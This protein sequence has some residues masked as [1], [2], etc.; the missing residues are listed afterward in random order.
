[1]KIQVEVNGT[2]REFQADARE[3]VRDLL[4]REGLLSVRNG[5]DGQ[6]T[7]G[8]CSILLDGKVV[9]SCLLLAPQV[10]GRKIRTAEHLSRDRE[11]SAVQTAFIDAGV[12]Q[13]GYCTPALLLAT[14]ELLARH[15]RPSREQVQDAFSGIFCRCTGYQQLFAAV[16]LAARRRVEPAHAA[17]TAPEFRED[18]RVVGKVRRKVDAPRLVRAEKSYVED[19][20]EPGACH[21]RMLGSP[22]A[23]AYIKRLDTRAAEAMP[24]V[25][26]VLTHRNTPEVYYNQAGQGFPEPSPYDRRLFGQKVLHVGDRVAAVVAETPEIAAEALRKIRVEYEVLKPVL[27][28]E[29]AAAPDAPRLH[30][31]VLEYVTGAPADLD[32]SGADPRD[33]KVLYQFPIHADPRR[34][35]A[36]SVSGGIGDVEAGLRQAEVVLEREYET[37]QVQCT[38]LEPHVVYT[39]M[40]GERLVIH[41]STQVPW[42]VRRIV[43]RVLGVSENQV[44]VI[45]ERI[46]GGFGA[47]QDVVL[48]EVAAYA[49]WVTRRP[50]LYR[51]TREEE[52]IASRTRHPMKIRVTLGARKDGK[53]TAIRMNVR[54]NTGP[55]GAHCLTV[56]MNAC[57]KSL[58]LLLCENVRFDVTTYYSNIPP[59]GAYQG[60]GAPQGS[61]ALQLACAEMAEQLGVDPLAFLETNRVRDGS[62]LEILRCL[63]EGREGRPQAVS[64]CGLGPALQQGAEMLRWGAPEASADP[65]VRIGKGVAI[66]QQASGLPGI[67]S[68]NAT[69][70]LLGDGTLMLLSGGTDLGTGLDTLMVKVVAECLCAPMGDVSLIVADTDVTPYDDGAYASSGTFFSGSAALNAA[71]DMKQKILEVAAGLLGEPVADLELAYPS[72]VQGK[73]GSAS[74][75]QVARATQSGTGAGQ[76][77][78]TASFTTDKAAFPY[79]AHFCQAAVNT[80]TGA[81][82]LQKYYALQ[83]CGTPIN[84]ELALGQIYGGALKTI[85]HSLYEEMLLDSKGRCLNANL[86]DYKV[87]M[88]RDLPADFR[89]V[90]VETTDPFGPYGGKSVSE[91]SCNGAAPAIAA[92]IHDATGVWLRS[93]PFTPEKIL[94]ALG[95][96]PG[97]ARP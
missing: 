1:M 40:D 91:I 16:E 33:G 59:C 56:P 80:R 32:N 96:L 93:W 31:A 63:G 50:V 25:V 2:R 17:Q 8:A 13:C 52:F 7:C 11:L 74:F 66:I 26:L 35:I 20:V 41:A 92:A 64:S 44:R 51:L 48:E 87:P 15:P 84:P 45:K 71:R 38:P 22:H 69:V 82:Q 37:S 86:L 24:G 4:R 81:V 21:L 12:V 47:K 85:G 62:M 65:D 90:L 23:H 27:T 77:S 19:M 97:P 88:I 9:N 75:T 42:H 72:T 83:D 34:N 43:A 89:A 78:C 73:S 68:S 30:N 76:L 94:R 54:A 49:T 58:P 60:Y 36:A 61:Y 55:Y 10:E 95:R 29:E 70:T 3:R 67:D 5:C 53:L 28:V 57:S 79:G 39:R 18:L 14:E 46:G 6:G